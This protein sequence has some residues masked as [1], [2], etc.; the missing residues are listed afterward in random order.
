M[1]G[2]Q[3]FI[4][5]FIIVLVYLGN[6]YNKAKNELEMVKRKLQQGEKEYKGIFEDSP[7]GLLK[8]DQ[9]LIITD[10]N[11]EMLAIF[12]IGNKKKVVQKRLFNL[13]D[14]NFPEI[15]KINEEKI[16]NSISKKKTKTSEV[17]LIINDKELWINY[18]LRPIYDDNG[19]INEI[20]MACKDITEKKVAEQEIEYLYFHDSL[21]GLYN[22]SYFNE[23]LKRYDSERQLPLSIILGDVNGLKLTNDAFG[24]NIGDRLLK[25]A[26]NIIK[27][28]CRQED[29][30]ARWGG[31]EF[32]ILLPQSDENI[33]HDICSRIK[34]RFEEIDD[35]ELVEPGIALGHA[36]KK[37]IKEDFQEVFK[38]AEELMY[39]NKLNES[40]N[41]HSA[42]IASL[43]Q[44][45]R[46][47]T[48]ETEGH[49]QRIKKYALD[50]GK[51]LGLS[52]YQL[53]ELSLLA[54]LHDL[55]KV[56][57]SESII[58]KPGPLSEEEFN[59]IKRHSEIGYQIASASGE[60]SSIAEGILCHH[61]YYDGS[62]YPQGLS[63][64]EIS[65]H[66][67]I[68]AVVDA[69]DIMINSSRPYKYCMEVKEAVRELKKLAGIQF[70][71]EIVDIFVNKVIKHD[72]ID[73]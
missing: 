44:T 49:C 56:G 9:D 30:I 39:K 47:S 19:D 28:C 57:I 5:I 12:N 22:R 32:I 38:K 41:A 2:I 15:I 33:A 27:E 34:M 53:A 14:I 20:I 66:G 8:L 16:E 62:G 43:R 21:T 70:D 25:K 54:E 29:L 68:I 67:R 10:I 11:K 1:Y 52:E 42:I 45:L 58:A 17:K 55:G 18:Y 31:D 63:G 60:L 3:V 35:E 40:K 51:A 37:K 13:P 24:H 6:K 72:L 48:F 61:E 7:I 23:E 36:T 26:A 64:D 4:I 50:L 59:K 73:I 69:Y 46:E 71:P 65:L